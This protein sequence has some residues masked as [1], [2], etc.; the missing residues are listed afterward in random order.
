RWDDVTRL[1][2]GMLSLVTCFEDLQVYSIAPPA[3][4]H[5]HEFLS[6]H[7][8]I[9]LAGTDDAVE[10]DVAGHLSGE[11]DIGIAVSHFGV[12]PQ[13]H[14]VSQRIAAGHAIAE[15]CRQHGKGGRGV[16]TA[17][18]HDRTACGNNRGRFYQK[19][20]AVFDF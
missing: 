19:I 12:R 1:Q 16:A 20:T 3:A 17:A 7:L 5:R 13:H 14:P 2:S 18:G 6:R 10:I 11:G 15:L 8:S 9:D 4:L